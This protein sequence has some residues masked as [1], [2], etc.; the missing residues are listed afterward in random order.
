V[1]RTLPTTTASEN[2][3]GFSIWS[4]FD[5]KVS[6]IQPTGTNTSRTIIEVLRYLEDVIQNRNTDALKWLMDN[7]HYYPYLSQLA[8]RKLCCLG[9][10][11]PCERVFSKAGLLISDRRSRLSSKKVEML[12][13]LNQNS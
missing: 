10:S 7:K 1:Q 2:E 9:T 4:S 12:H 8:R 5:S 3:Q 11:V 13:F 6:Q